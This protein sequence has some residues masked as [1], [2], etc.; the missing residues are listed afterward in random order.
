MKKALVL[1]LV[2][3]MVPKCE[4]YCQE[5]GTWPVGSSS[6]TLNAGTLI[7]ATPILINYEHLWH[8]KK[9]HI[10][11]STGIVTTFLEGFS[12]ETLGGY[13]A[14]VLMTGTG[15]K[16]FEGRLG[17]SYHPIYIYP[18]AGA[19]KTYLF[20]IPVINLGYRYQPPGDNI[21]YRVSI[22][23]GGFGLGI[24]FVLGQEKREK[25]TQ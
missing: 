21:Y 17:G 24:G 23:T 25:V 1:W 14:M 10:G 4:L 15:N 20:F 7:I 16:H 19:Q 12:S 2:I 22:G 18:G 13:L 6:I 5:Q 9:I 3:F 11:L 8:R